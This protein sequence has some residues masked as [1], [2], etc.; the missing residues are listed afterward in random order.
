MRVYQ[1][2]TH[3]HSERLLFFIFKMKDLS[4]FVYRKISVPSP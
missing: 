4:V 1:I 3:H 2:R